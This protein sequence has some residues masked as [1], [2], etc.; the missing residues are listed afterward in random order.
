MVPVRVLLSTL[1]ALSV[2]TA[3]RAVAQ[4]AIV[5]STGPSALLRSKTV[6]ADLKLGEAQTA[7]LDTWLATHLADLDDRRRAAVSDG[8]AAD[9]DKAA[10]INQA[11]SALYATVLDET[12]KVL[13]AE[14]VRRL[15]QIDLQTAGVSGFSRSAVG[16]EL[17]LTD[18]QS[19]VVREAVSEYGF[20]VKELRDTGADLKRPS[21]QQDEA[22]SAA[23]ARVVAA[24]TPEQAAAYKRLCG[25]PI[26]VAVVRAESRKRTD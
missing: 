13:T 1:A 22:A 17:K 2:A 24:L 25:E 5:A 7:K 19:E 26:N 23:L 3:P 9:G 21:T 6:R 14:Q 18:T 16:A 11:L 8:M 15:R 4:T 20:K 12:G 10:A